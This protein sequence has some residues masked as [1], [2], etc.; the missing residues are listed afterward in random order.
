MIIIAKNDFKLVGKDQQGHD[1]EFKVKKGDK[2]S[3]HGTVFNY[4]GLIIDVSKYDNMFDIAKEVHATEVPAYE[5]IRPIVL[6]LPNS[7]NVV[8]IPVGTVI[9]TTR[10]IVIY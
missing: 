5:V 8:T 7:S 4:N 1:V 2:F 3:L 6:P 10:D 9:R